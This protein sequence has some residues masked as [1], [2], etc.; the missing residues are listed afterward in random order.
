[1]KEGNLEV[2]IYVCVCV[3]T[4]N[5]VY[6]GVLDSHVVVFFGMFYIAID[7]KVWSKLDESAEAAVGVGWGWGGGGGGEPKEAS[8]PWS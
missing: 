2:Y 3:Y 8:L 6:V 1:M 5:A 7:C 4:W